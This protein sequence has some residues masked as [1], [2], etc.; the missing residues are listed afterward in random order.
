MFELGTSKAQVK[1]VTLQP[2]CFYCTLDKFLNIHT[3]TWSYR[4][5]LRKFIITGIINNYIC[6]R[7]N[8]ILQTGK[9][10]VMQ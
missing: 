8:L 10:G 7:M 9:Q 5:E 6:I 3:L 2:T 4:M 1:N